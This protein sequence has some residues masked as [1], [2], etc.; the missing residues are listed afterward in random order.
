MR[1]NKYSMIITSAITIIALILAITLNYLELD[2]YAN[3]F[4]G[5]F[6][7]G[8]LTFILAIV[9]YLVERKRTL[10]KFYSYSLKAIANYNKFENDGNL[11]RTIDIILQMDSFDYL[12]LDNAYGDISFLFNNRSNREYIYNSIYGV[13]MELRQLIREKA[14]HFREYRKPAPEGTRVFRNTRVMQEFVNEIDAQIM[15]RTEQEIQKDDGTAVKI[16]SAKNK[17]VIALCE[18]LSG[19][20]YRIMYPFRKKEDTQ[21]AR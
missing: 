1:I 12:E 15:N 8:L 6:A 9:G 13:T 14:F 4:S 11:E 19:R 3:L 18:E 16:S 7:S 17:I 20:Y 5:I 10:E 21:N 2:F